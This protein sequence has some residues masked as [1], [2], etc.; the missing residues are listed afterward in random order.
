L[1][2][3]FKT[4]ELRPLLQRLRPVLYIG[5]AALYSQVASID[6]SILASNSRFVT[7]PLTTFGSSHGP[8]YLPRPTASRSESLRTWTRPLC[9]LRPPEPPASRNS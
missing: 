3:R 5:Q 7:A 2:I 6:P 9:C 4:A 1:N 8:D